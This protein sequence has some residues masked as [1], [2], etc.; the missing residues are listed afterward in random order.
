MNTMISA[1]HNDDDR[2]ALLGRLSVALQKPQKNI[3]FALRAPLQRLAKAN[4]RALWVRL[5][6]G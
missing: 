5:M 2:Q 3:T 1:P 4:W 6:H